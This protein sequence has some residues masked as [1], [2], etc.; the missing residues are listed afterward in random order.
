MN[1]LTLTRRNTWRKPL[2]TVLLIVCVAV[3][4]LIYG[5]SASFL[6]GSQGT[7]ASSENVLGV[8]HAA[9]LSQSLPLA[10][11]PRIAAEPDVAAVTPMARLRGFVERENNVVAVSAVDP[12]QLAAVNGQEL[13]LTPSLV[14]ALGRSRDRVLVGRALASAQGWAVGDRIAL[15]AFDTPLQDGGRIWRFEIAGIFEGESASTDTYF[16]LARYDY[17]NAARARNKDTVSAFAVRPRPSARPAELAARLD[18]LFSNSAAPTR[19]QSEKQFLEAFLRQYADIGRVLDLVVGAAFI[20]LLM[21]VVNTMVFAVRERRFEIG[22]LKTLGF[23]SPRIVALILSETL[24]VFAVGGGLGLALAKFA[25][26]YA[27]PS[28]GLV[29]SATVLAKAV[30]IVGVLGFACGVLPAVRAIRTPVVSA[31]RT[32]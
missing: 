8:M 22:V 27:A 14:E 12:V 13:A 1:H 17:I 4:F 24:W 23:S 29:F 3:A 10:Y 31:L 32:R 30:F 9:G 11:L 19:T 6:H 26:L 20:T 16:M 21:I 28:L 25:T 5:L 7:A 18:T 15:S 2:R